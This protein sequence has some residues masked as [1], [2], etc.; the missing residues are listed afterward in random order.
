MSDLG[1]GK[2][3]ISY[4]NKCKAPL[5]HIIVVM[6]DSLNIGKVECKTCKTVHAYK[7]PSKVRA[8]KSATGTTRKKKATGKKE[9]VADLWLE[10]V[11]NSTAKSKAALA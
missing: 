10:A 9:S 7:D 11:N 5:A 1:V 3:V 2:E 4:C 8:K 6:K